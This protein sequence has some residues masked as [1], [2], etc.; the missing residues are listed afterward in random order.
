MGSKN[1]L[2][3]KP[4]TVTYPRIS[5]S[6][7]LRISQ[8]QEGLKVDSHDDIMASEKL[9]AQ[10]IWGQTEDITPEVVKAMS[11]MSHDAEEGIDDL[12]DHCSITI[13]GTLNVGGEGYVQLATQHSLERNV[14]IKRLKDPTQRR[15]TERL[16]QEA[17]LTGSL[18]HPNIIP[19]HALS[20]SP[21]GD[22]MIVMKRVEG[23]SWGM[24][25]GKLGPIWSADKSDILN[26]HLGIFLQVCR[27]VEFAHSKGVLHL[28]IK[29]E[30]VMLGD[31]GEV[32]LVDWGIAKRI[33][34]VETL[35]TSY[36]AGTPHFMASEMTTS[37]RSVTPRTDVAVL[38]ATLHRVVMGKARYRGNNLTAILLAA[39]QAEPV[40]FPPEMHQELGA[41][42]N[43]ACAREPEQRF[44]S[45]AALRQAIEH[46]LNHRISIELTREA[47]Q[48]LK[49]LIQDEKRRE[50]GD[51]ELL[52]E[53]VFREYA[54]TCRISLERAIENWPEN[55]HA[56]VSLDQLRACWATFEM[57]HNQLQTAEAMLNQ[58]KYPSPSLFEEL[59]Q[60]SLLLKSEAIEQDKLREIKHAMTFKSTLRYQG[61]LI[62]LNGLF[63]AVLMMGINVLDQKG[64]ITFDQH[65]NF[66]VS[67]YA[68]LIVLA[69]LWL[70]WPLFTDTLWRKRFTAAYVSYLTLIYLFRPLSFVLDLNIT[71]SLTIDGV[72]LTLFMGQ[73]AAFIHPKMWFAAVAGGIC[74]LVSLVY[75]EWLF[76]TLAT[77]VFMG[78]CC[79]A[80]IVG[81]SSESE[82]ERQHHVSHLNAEVS[83]TSHVDQ[84]HD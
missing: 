72:L 65:F 60:R 24:K 16:I 68:W 70:Y 18:E 30:N 9:I 14:A 17:R 22:P 61:V 63:W 2:S 53:G 32:Y 38:G 25:V 7:L 44:E 76:P 15:Q 20:K 37:L 48:I 26:E 39:H 82:A 84:T 80:W 28:D 41:I 62:V 55:W 4:T 45:V 33:S 11:T 3:D 29:P 47:T 81:F 71:Q 56:Q 46:Y 42:I 54:L 50:S 10:Q 83:T 8:E 34:E 75:P 31:F 49:R 66:E 13:E 23:S 69:S 27:A 78:N 12:G 21:D 6:D 5:K 77:S 36:I 19:I 59:K 58:M 57:H 35:P 52:S 64:V 43:T 1:H 74:V 40:D 79:L 51:G 73:V 67:T